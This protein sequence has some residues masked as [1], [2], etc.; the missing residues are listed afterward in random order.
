V[1]INPTYVKALVKLG[2]TSWEAGRLE[3]A[4]AVLQRAI[5]LQPEYVDLHY[6]LGLVYA[7]QGLWPMAVEQYQKALARQPGA[8]GVQA[9]LALALENMGLAGEDALPLATAPVAAGGAADEK[10]AGA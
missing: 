2:L 8:E 6:R 7:D 1:A 10:S 4:Q 9:S 3:E 5:H